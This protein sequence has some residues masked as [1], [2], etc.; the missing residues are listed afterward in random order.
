MFCI[1]AFVVL[2]IVSIF[3]ASHRRAAKKAW[4][5][6][7]RRVTFRPCDTNFKD[8]L[9]GSMLAK[10][11]VRHPRLVPTAGI[12]IEIAA[13]IFIIAT[14]WS[15]FVAAR[16]GL[17]LYVYGTC[18]P[19]N[20]ASCSLGAEACSIESARPN[21]W[22]S[23][24]K[25][26]VI[27]WV[28]ADV[29]ELGETLAAV[30]TKI[31]SW[32]AKNYLPPNASY[33]KPFEQSKPTALEIVDPGCK[34]CAQLMK[35]LDDSGFVDKYNLTYIAYP[36]T[37]IKNG[38]YKFKNS[39]LVTQYLEAIRTM[40]L[41]NQATP[42]DWKILHRIYTESDGNVTW[43]NKINVILNEGQVNDLIKDWLKEFGYS[44]EQIGQ[45]VDKANSEEI[46][47]IIENNK[48]LVEE[49]IKTKK[50]PTIIYDGER[51]DGVVSTDKLKNTDAR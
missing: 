46:K 20:A 30:P 25:G 22:D 6:V 35:N 14:I 2:A 31:Q 13:W 12:A 50:I 27:D 42:A 49:K 44:D 48:K 36:I 47:T 16:S 3:S 32:D 28:V 18:T 17:N 15:L 7:G 26:E 24:K 4:A 38:G 51:H 33:Y 9:K 8:D 43:Q 40:P 39:M 11:A 1:A 37:D 23:L 5:C 41:E 19:S 10:V 34:F 21:F 29:K 45:I